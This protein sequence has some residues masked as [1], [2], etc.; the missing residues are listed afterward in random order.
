MR[1]FLLLFLFIPITLQAQQIVIKDVTLLDVKKQKLLKDISVVI[2]GD[3]IS[4]IDKFS[5]LTI[6]SDDS[7]IEASGKYLIPG[8][9]DAHI[10]FFQS[11]GLYTRPDALNLTS[12]RPYSEEI[13]FAKDNAGDYMRRYLRNGITTVMDVGGPFWNFT[14]RD[15]I[16]PSQTSPNVLVTGP[17][18]SMVD[19]PQLDKG[20]PPIIKMT[21]TEDVDDLFNKMLPYK[22]DFMKVW[23]VVTR[24]NPAEK[25][26]PIVEHLGKLCKQNNLK[27]TVHATQLKTAELAVKAG[28]NILVHS[29]DDEIVPK[30]FIDLL[31]KNNVTYIP[32][33][34]VMNGY[35]RAFTGI[36]G[37]TKEDLEW[38][39]PVPYNSLRDL[40]KLAKDQ[41]PGRLSNIYGTDPSLY[42]AKA[43]SIMIQNLKL[44]HDAGV[45]IATGTDAGNIGTMHASSYMEELR[46]MKR[47]EL[48]NWDILTYSTINPAKG[49]GLNHQI[50]SLAEGKL[51][52]MII[53]DKNPLDDL[54]NLKS[55]STIIKSGDVLDPATVLQETPEQIVQRQVNAYNARDIEAFL[56]TYSED[57]EIYN[58][59][60]EMT[61]KGHEQMRA[62]YAGMFQ[63]VPNLYCNI[64]NRIAYNNKVVDKELVRF[65]DRYA[66]VIA[67]YEVTDGKISKVTFLR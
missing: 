20:D 9:I 31:K 56:D 39:H 44:L 64:E 40:N 34:T 1:Y 5:K 3:K 24:D 11:G 27:L 49:F 14:V 46:A 29:V 32:T 45:N 59:N 57:V 41:L 30:S 35:Y 47:A 60:G 37:D 17:L 54:E 21:S 66:E 43:D 42:S 65:N 22:P 23:Y 38:A 15:S 53:L 55:I 4:S 63:S 62:S 58:E 6:S 12:I 33:L 18:F 50:G 28:A 26:Y 61:M 19:R 7:V 67:V 51:A 10:H 8:L 48:S 25:S 52:D 13:Q 36:I 2:E 16:A